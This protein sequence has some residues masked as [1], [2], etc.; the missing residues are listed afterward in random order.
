MKKLYEEYLEKE[1]LTVDEAMEILY[2]GRNTVYDLLEKGERVC[3]L[4][5]IIHNENVVSELESKG[6][7]SLDSLENVEKER[8]TFT[9]RTN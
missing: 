9:G 7:F 5:P 1:L 3:T 6:V 8:K 4:G 2:L